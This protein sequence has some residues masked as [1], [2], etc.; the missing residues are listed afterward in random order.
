[1]YLKENGLTH[2]DYPF[3]DDDRH[4]VYRTRCGQLVWFVAG[5]APVTCWQCLTWP[6]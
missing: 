3:A 4:G 6:L 1:M 5:Q 2:L